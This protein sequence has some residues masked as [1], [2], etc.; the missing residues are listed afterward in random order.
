M[1]EECFVINNLPKGTL[2][3][4]PF[5]LMKDEVLGQDYTLTVNFISSEV[6]QKLNRECR[7]KDFP[8]DILSFPLS[9]EEGEI[10]I[11]LAESKKEAEKFNRKFENFVAFLFIHGLVH[12]KGYDHGSTM[13]SI[14]QD[15]RKKFGV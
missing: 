6:S 11:D 15:F 12:L 2:E 8:T 14:E 13:E 5:V 9:K 1:K 4:V 7:N 10:Y 3:S